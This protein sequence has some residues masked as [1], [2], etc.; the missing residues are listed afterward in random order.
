MLQKTLNDEKKNKTD[1]CFFE[2]IVMPSTMFMIPSVACCKIPSSS[3]WIV[4]RCTLL[5]KY[6]SLTWKASILLFVNVQETSLSS[7]SQHKSM[8]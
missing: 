5:R 2:Q 4:K 1:V 6:A 8:C 7:K 3:F